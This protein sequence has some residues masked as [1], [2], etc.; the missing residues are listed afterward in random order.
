VR[1]ALRKDT[2]AGPP[3]RQA[4]TDKALRTAAARRTSALAGVVPHDGNVVSRGLLVVFL[5]KLAGMLLDIPRIALHVIRVLFDFFDLIVNALN[6]VADRVQK[7]Q[8]GKP[9]EPFE[10]QL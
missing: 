2:A 6:R 5:Q 3:A 8:T 10:Q 7:A 9:A 4:A 1:A